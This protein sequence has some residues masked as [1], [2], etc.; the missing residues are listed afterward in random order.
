VGHRKEQRA[1]G[2]QQQAG[3]DAQRLRVAAA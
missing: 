1:Q 3:A 2:H